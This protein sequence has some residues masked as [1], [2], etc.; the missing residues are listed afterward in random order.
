MENAVIGR[1]ILPGASVPIVARRHS[2]TSFW[3][4]K[5]GGFFSGD[6]LQLQ[7]VKSD[8]IEIGTV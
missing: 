1:S 4:Y 5:G 2:A 6:Q 8:V 3:F 7:T